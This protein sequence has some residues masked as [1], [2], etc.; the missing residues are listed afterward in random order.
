VAHATQDRLH[1]C[2]ADGDSPAESSGVGPVQPFTALCVRC[3]GPMGKETSVHMESIP[4]GSLRRQFVLRDP[5]K[6]CLTDTTRAVDS[7][8]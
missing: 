2:M 6:V 3:I 1:V 5:A 8:S 4:R 7:L